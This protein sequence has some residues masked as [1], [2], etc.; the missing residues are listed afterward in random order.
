MKAIKEENAE[1]MLQAMQKGLTQQMVKV[2]PNEMKL[3][4]T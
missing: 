4:Q 3:N 2:S 1:I